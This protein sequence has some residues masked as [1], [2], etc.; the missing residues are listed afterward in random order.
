M[1]PA[2]L[3]YPD[4]TLSKTVGAPILADAAA[5]CALATSSLDSDVMR[6]CVLGKEEYSKAIMAFVTSTRRPVAVRVQMW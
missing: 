3:H 1:I 6:R 4:S 2:Y 5:A